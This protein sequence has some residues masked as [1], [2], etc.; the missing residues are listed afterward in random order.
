M[1]RRDGDGGV[2]MSTVTHVWIV[3]RT[4]EVD[5][6]YVFVDDEQARAYAARFPDAIVSEEVVMDRPAGAQFLVDEADGEEPDDHSSR[7][8]DARNEPN[9]AALTTLLDQATD[10]AVVLDA[11]AHMLRDPDWGVGML[12][13][14]AGLVA[15]TGRSLDSPSEEPTWD[16]H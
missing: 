2:A 13:D 3:N 14:I 1:E 4:G 9:A 15:D 12:E 11:I 7:K 10:D 8:E 16:R 5:P 6:L